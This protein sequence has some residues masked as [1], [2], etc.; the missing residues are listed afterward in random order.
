M[1]QDITRAPAAFV[2]AAHPP[3]SRLVFGLFLVR[4]GKHLA[5]LGALLIVG[6]A[7]GHF[8]AGQPAILALIV[9][10]AVSHSSGK[11]Y[12]TRALAFRKRP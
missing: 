2:A 10:S 5:V 8:G 3:P 11:A 12:L 4:L 7:A 6:R 1:R 9:L